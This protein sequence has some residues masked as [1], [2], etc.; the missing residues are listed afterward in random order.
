MVQLT[1]CQIRCMSRMSAGD[2]EAG[3]SVGYGV[4][5]QSADRF[6]WSYPTAATNEVETYFQSN[7][8][9]RG[10]EHKILCPLLSTLVLFN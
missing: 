3:Q 10:S 8:V 1:L 9:T 7:Y 5:D 4:V 6:V 2:E